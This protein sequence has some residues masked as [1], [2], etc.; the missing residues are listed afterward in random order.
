MLNEQKGNMYG[1]VTHT[2]NYTKGKCSHDCKYCYMKGW[3]EQRPLRLDETELREDMGENKYIFVGSSTDMFADDVPSFWI[4]KALAHC[5]DYDN[6][7]LF[8]TKNPKRFL[9]FLTFF[10][11]NSIL[12]VTIESNRRYKEMGD[13]PNPISRAAYFGN[14][15][16]F[17]KM[18]TVEPIMDFDLIPFVDL[19]KSIKPE[20][21]NIG[22]D[23]KKHELPEPSKEKINL[24]VARLMKFTK[25]HLKDNLKRLMEE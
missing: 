23:S 13:T 4:E 2:K 8:Q 15:I 7:Y 16:K 5:N 22:A 1:F 24:L 11:E 18:V 9:G 14:S 17:R 6:T 20:Q 10:P 3:G 21:V 19:I 12:C 25:V